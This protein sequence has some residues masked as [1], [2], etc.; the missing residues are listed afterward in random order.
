M[1]KWS[2]SVQAGTDNDWH[3]SEM[4][5]DQA[6]N[7]LRMGMTPNGREIFIKHSS[8]THIHIN[9]KGEIAMKAMGQSSE[10]YLKGKNIEVTGPM[11]FVCK[12][13]VTITSEK[14]L[15]FEGKSIA[16]KATGGNI[17]MK[18]DG[19][20]NITME[21]ENFIKSTTGNTDDKTG[22]RYARTVGGDSNETVNGDRQVAAKNNTQTVSGDNTTMTGGEHSISAGGTMGLGAA[23]MGIASTGQTTIKAVG[24]TMNLEASS[25][26][27][28]KGSQIQLNP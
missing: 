19:G 5:R 16:L 6:G 14:Q 12:D 9:D 24:G 18:A 28:I 23:E 4:Y 20:G 25:T 3:G 17:D 26:N 2:E 8:G 10:V 21:S 1:P 22:G 27:T 11:H 15:N 13:D 7:E